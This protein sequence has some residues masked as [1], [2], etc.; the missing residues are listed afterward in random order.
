MS[1]YRP[2]RYVHKEET[3]C[4]MRFM[5]C[6]SSDAFLLHKVFGYKTMT[7]TKMAIELQMSLWMCSFESDNS[8][9]AESRMAYV[10][11]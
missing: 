2:R 1:L 3:D 8:L 11:Y 9:S 4:V 7:K 10:K 6:Q 5:W